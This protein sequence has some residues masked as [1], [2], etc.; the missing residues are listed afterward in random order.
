MSESIISE[1]IMPG[2]VQIPADGQPIILLVEQT[3]GGYSKIAT[4]ISADLPKLA[5]AI[6]G[7]TIRFKPAP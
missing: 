7:K 2:S 4:V 3:M 5:Q 1:P 6:P